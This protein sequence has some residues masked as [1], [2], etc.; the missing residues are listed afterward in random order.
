MARILVKGTNSKAH[1]NVFV[2]RAIEQQKIV[3]ARKVFA[4]DHS[5]SPRFAQA[6]C[7]FQIRLAFGTVELLEAHSV[8][9]INE[10]KTIGD[11]HV[12]V[13][14]PVSLCLFARAMV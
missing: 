13:G 1:S 5:A 10:A 9:D 11:A 6:Y 4:S 3:P 12:H 2:Y 7:R 14:N 8:E